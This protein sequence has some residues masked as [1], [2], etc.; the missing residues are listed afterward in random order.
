VRGRKGE[1]QKIFEQV[2]RDG[3]VRVRVDGKIRDV[4]EK[5]ELAKYKKHDIEAVVDRLI[6]KRD[7][8]NRLAES[9]ETALH[10]GSGIL[11]V[12]RTAP[13]SASNPCASGSAK[14]GGRVLKKAGQTGNRDEIFSE[15]FACVHCGISYEE[16][17]PRMFS[18]NS[19]YGAC[20]VC[21]GLATKL[22]LDPN[23]VIPDK[24]KSTGQKQEYKRGSY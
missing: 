3:F 2:R 18:F 12:N 16:L 5:I 4:D 23:L 20:P 17:A 24:S 10:M 19:P 6:I 15:H 9:V 1:Y 14:K 21:D 7:V 11:I 22:E 13:A 8:K